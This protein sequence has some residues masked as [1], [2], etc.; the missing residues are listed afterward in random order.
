MKMLPLL[1]LALPGLAWAKAAH[2]SPSYHGNCQSPRWSPDGSKLAFEV[3]Y[4]DR[5]LIEQYVLVPGQ[6]APES[7]KPSARGASAIAAGFSRS[8]SSE[9]VVHELSWAPVSIGRF[10]YS[11]S[12]ADRDYDIYISKTS[13]PIVGDPG[14]DGGPKWSPDG[15]HIAFTSARTGQGDI[16]LV[17]TQQVDAQPQRLTS[18]PTSAELYLC[19]SP[20]GQKLAFVGHSDDGDNLYLAEGVVDLRAGSVQQ[21][22][23]G[24]TA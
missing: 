11:A 19:W 13:E 20:D 12:G 14:A 10:V 7:V 24:V 23:D 9:M 15:R 4:H 16:Y 2:L 6:G 1:L 18:Y 21:C 3:N 22:S 8:S 17:D 5:K